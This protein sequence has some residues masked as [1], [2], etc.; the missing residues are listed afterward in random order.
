MGC[1]G[2]SLKA[3]L[4]PH[5]SEDQLIEAGLLKR[6]ETGVVGDYFR[7]RIMFPI[8]DRRKRVIAFGGRALG[9][10]QPKYINSPETPVFHKGHI[11]YNLAQAHSE[12]ATGHAVIVAEGYMDVIAFARAGGYGP[13]HPLERR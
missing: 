5:I 10:R 1:W 13:L 4:H 8:T 6:N 7:N 2:R 9:D 11:L 3:S 12:K